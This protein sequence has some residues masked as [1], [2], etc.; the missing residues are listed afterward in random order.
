MVSE[1][2]QG[3]TFELL[4]PLAECEDLGPVA[5]SWV[6]RGT[7]QNIL[8]VDDDTSLL[9]VTEQMLERQ[10]YSVRSF[11]RPSEA[12]AAMES[13]EG[14]FA[15]VITDYRMPGMD[16]MSFIEKVNR[17][18]PGIPIVL[19]SAYLSDELKSHA[20]ELGVRSLLAKPTTS[21]EI[22]RSVH[23]ALSLSRIENS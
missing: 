20:S 5:S 11:S 16:G 2:G 9:S 22:C 19:T 1:P 23:Q 12:L 15:L 6:G 10:G 13:G 7:G 14:T 17:I 3:A 18:H 21:E 4:F 8:L